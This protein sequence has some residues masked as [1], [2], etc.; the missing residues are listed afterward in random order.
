MNEGVIH[1]SIPAPPPK[2]YFETPLMTPL[3]TLLWTPYRA[4]PPE[5]PKLSR[6]FLFP[7]AAPYFSTSNGFRGPGPQQ[8]RR[9]SSEG[10]VSRQTSWGVLV[11]LRQR[12]S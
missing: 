6:L 8:L 5:G 4:G 3:M 1:L 10:E 12:A 2:T 11:D 7:P 9:R